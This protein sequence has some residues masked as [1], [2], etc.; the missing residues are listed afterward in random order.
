MLAIITR[1]KANIAITI[2][3]AMSKAVLM[4]MLAVPMGA[5]IVTASN[6]LFQSGY[7]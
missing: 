3:A 7:R 6:L 1:S 2:A 5:S 4:V